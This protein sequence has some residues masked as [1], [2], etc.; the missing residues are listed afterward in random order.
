MLANVTDNF[1]R[2]A[3]QPTFWDI[4]TMLEDD[5]LEIYDNLPQAT[6]DQLA[7]IPA[8]NT[9][10]RQGWTDEVIGFFRL[11]T[12]VLTCRVVRSLHVHCIDCCVRVYKYCMHTCMLHILYRLKCVYSSCKTLTA[13]GARDARSNACSPINYFCWPMTSF[14]PISLYIPYNH[15]HPSSIAGNLTIKILVARQHPT[16][17]DVSHTMSCHTTIV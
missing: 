12:Q 13:W 3:D 10:T 16:N 2:N 6:R 15:Q 1:T 9:V 5:W 17:K 14:H 7:A 11:M 4:A 8:P